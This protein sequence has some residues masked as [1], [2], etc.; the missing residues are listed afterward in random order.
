MQNF[1]QLP[2]QKSKITL[3]GYSPIFMRLLINLKIFLLLAFYPPCGYALN[4]DRNLN[5]YNSKQWGVDEQLPQISV[6]ALVQEK[7]G[8]I[9]IGTQ[10]GIARFNGK[11]FVGFDRSNTK[12]LQSNIINDLLIDQQDIL[13]VLTDSGLVLQDSSGFIA[14][15]D[16]DTLLIKPT[17]LL[18]Y[19]GQILVSATSGLFT[20]INRR[21]LPYAISS[22]SYSSES[23]SLENSSLG[24]LVGGRGQ[25]T[26]IKNNV[27]SINRLPARFEKAVIIDIQ[28]IGQEIWLATSKGMLFYRDGQFFQLDNVTPLTN[29]PTNA[30]YL[31]ENQILWV[32]TD[33]AT[34]RIKQKRLHNGNEK[35]S[36]QR[37]SKFMSDKDGALW[38]GTSDRGLFQLWNSWAV[39]YGEYQGI[40]ENLIWSVTGNSLSNLLIGTDNG[41]Y[42]YS[43]KEFTSLISKQ[44]LP[45]PSAYTLFIDDDKSIWVGTKGGIAHFDQQGNRLYEKH[46]DG[47]LGLQINA[48][49]RD[50]QQAL[51]ILT[52][53]GV[54]RKSDETLQHIGIGTPFESESFRAVVELNKTIYLGSQSGLAYFDLY[55]GLHKV[56]DKRL[57][58]FITA[59]DIYQGR[60]L[61]GTYSE[62]LFVR[63]EEQWKNLSKKNGLVFNNS[64]SLNQLKDS[65]WVSGFDGVYR[66]AYQ[67]L[68]AFIDDKKDGVIT[69]AILKDSGYAI[70]SQKAYCCNGAGHA[71]STKIGGDMWFPTRKGVLKLQPD[72][73]RKNTTLVKTV[74]ESLLINQ[75]EFDMYFYQKNIKGLHKMAFD[76]RDISFRFIGLTSF[77]EGL[78]KYRYRL[79]GYQ[80]KWLDNGADRIV[81][82]TN[83]PHGD[84]I[85][86]V[87]AGNNNGIWAKTPTQLAF[88]INPRYYQTMFFRL[89]IA[90]A[91][92]LLL[93]GSYRLVIYRNKK[94]VEALERM[95]S[96]KTNALLISNQK[97]AAANEKLSVYS[98][99]DPLTGAFNRRYLVK[100]M[101]SDIS[102]YIRNAR[103]EM[104]EQNIV[105]LLVDIDFFKDI[106]DSYGHNSGDE[107]LKQVVSVLQSNIR[108]GDYLIRWGGEE[109]LIALRPDHVSGIE[110]LCIRLLDRINNNRFSGSNDETIDLTVS[111][112]YCYY[113]MVKQVINNWAWLD[114]LDIADKG[115]YQAKSNGRNQWVGYQLLPNV[116]EEFSA[117][118]KHSLK[119]SSFQRFS[120]TC[121]SIK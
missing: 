57:K 79:L 96:D 7:I 97:L 109:F 18:E 116:L 29:E 115:L 53:Q 56:D 106:N 99:T 92:M 25:L 58:T 100:Q 40:K 105:F 28:V 55:F 120:G 17:K 35:P 91:T 87:V 83:L 12:A 14:I 77:D 3:C 65:L 63:V 2:V 4:P 60:L 39:R 41:V 11:E 64:F 80:E 48:I 34:Y 107:V 19:D 76:E 15:E 98:Y 23:Y 88:S 16:T 22:V 93:Y 6:T 86:E 5:E 75:Q 13:W 108:D 66:L 24:L 51:W 54:F 36:Y 31:D 78:V 94:K 44:Q 37:V 46:L 81:S 74:I 102:H 32:A 61:V 118:S 111:I 103:Q 113:P 52:G 110:E 101:L 21:I 90:L 50:S 47:L 10:N 33:I 20:I 121:Q 9:W 112:G 89:L 69:T 45:N 84:Y 71:K 73:V 67:S 68:N 43:G 27:S 95:V 85:F 8:Y 26:V 104:P 119:S 72:K 1:V 117:Q 42:Q 30:L 70:G 59:L 62:G 38:L 49:Y 114:A 82:Y